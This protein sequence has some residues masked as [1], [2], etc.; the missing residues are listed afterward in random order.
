MPNTSGCART[1]TDRMTPPYRVGPVNVGSMTACTVRPGPRSA[2]RSLP[3]SPTTG[4]SSP[5]RRWP[6]HCWCGA[7]SSSR[8]CA[9]AHAPQPRAALAKGEQRGAGDRW[10]VPRSSWSSRVRRDVRSRRTSSRAPS[11]RRCEIAVNG[12]RWGWTFAYRGGPASAGPRAAAG[13]GG[14]GGETIA[15]RAL[16][17]RRRTRVLG[18]GHAIQAR[19]DAGTVTVFDLTPT[20]TGTFLGRCAEF[21][22]LYHA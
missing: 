16:V 14:A 2:A 21:C 15:I 10:T 4:E 13:D 5:T 22:G 12:Y 3:R 18:A 20:K 9:S 19:R 6:S 8:R 11:T 17:E 1:A 7:S